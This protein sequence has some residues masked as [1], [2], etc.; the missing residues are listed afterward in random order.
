[1]KRSKLLPDA[2]TLAQNDLDA[3]RIEKGK[4]LSTDTL[5]PKPSFAQYMRDMVYG[6][7]VQLKLG[8]EKQPPLYHYVNYGD[9]GATSVRHVTGHELGNMSPEGHVRI[10]AIS[11]THERHESV[12]IP[13]CDIL[14][15]CGDIL[16]L[17]RRKSLHFNIQKLRSFNRWLGEIPAK[18]KVVIA[19]NHD[20]ALE[21]LPLSLSRTLLSNASHFLC[22]DSASIRGLTFFGSPYSAPG[23]RGKSPNVAYQD[24][25]YYA[26]MAR[27]LARIYQK[28]SRAVDVLVTHGPCKKQ[29]Q[30]CGGEGPMLHL[31]GHHHSLHGVQ[32][33]PPAEQEGASR[34][35][36]SCNSVI[37]NAK[38]APNNPPIVIDI[39]LTELYKRD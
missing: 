25:E 20:A 34:F 18:H 13:P 29:R 17:S 7:C 2:T 35:L 8:N 10:V 39:P 22:N 31:W 32:W 11:D 6:V 14:V 33:I 12:T 16:C 24:K 9:R 4:P 27:R 28:N 30:L 19:G 26:Q 1:M 15:H 23:S 37:M 36:L 38:Y 3:L 5:I 21:I